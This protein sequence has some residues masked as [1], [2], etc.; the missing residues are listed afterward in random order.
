MYLNL[1][2]C[3]IRAVW[4]LSGESSRLCALPVWFIPNPGP[5]G[6]LEGHISVHVTL[7]SLSASL[8]NNPSH[9]E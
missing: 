4:E 1:R 5:M 2:L 3:I 7:M 9:L 6:V 8:L